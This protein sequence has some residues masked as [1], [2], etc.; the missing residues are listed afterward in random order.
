M[1]TFF[2]KVAIYILHALH[3]AK[4]PSI[5]IIINLENLRKGLNYINKEYG[6]IE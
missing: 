5:M 1:A 2:L 6:A 4:L 3:E